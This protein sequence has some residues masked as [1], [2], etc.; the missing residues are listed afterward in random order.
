MFCIRLNK[1]S[2]GLDVTPVADVWSKLTPAEQAEFVRIMEDPNSD[3]ARQLLA[4]EELENERCEPWWD[5]PTA[6]SDGSRRYGSKPEL[7]LIPAVMVK[8]IPNGPP[9]HY[10]ICAVWYVA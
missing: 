5:A 3:H 1:I 7:I 2:R 6:E 4:S 8:P 9:L 10:N